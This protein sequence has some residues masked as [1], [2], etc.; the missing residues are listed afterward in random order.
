MGYKVARAARDSVSRAQDGIWAVEYML[1]HARTGYPAASCSSIEGV[2]RYPPLQ[3]Q[4]VRSA[5]KRRW[6]PGWMWF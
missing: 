1:D 6:L 4:D 2:C 3:D 5:P